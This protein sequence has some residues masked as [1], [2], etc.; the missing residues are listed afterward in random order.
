M[1][2]VKEITT[3]QELKRFVKFPFTLY[4]DSPYWVAPLTND[5][6]ETLDKTKNPVFKNATATYYLAYKEN[7]IVGR[8]AVIIN[9]L[10]IEEIGKKK[11]RFG[12]L[13]MIDDI[14]VTKALLEKVYEAGREN[15]L[16]YAEG[17]VGFS[18][19][20]KAGILTKGFEELNTMITWYHYPYYAEH[21]EKLGF[22]K[23]ATWVEY[24]LSIPAT[25]KE[26]VAKFSS[27]VKKRYELEVIEFKNKK[28]ILPY[29]NTMF[30]LLNKTYNSLQT[31]VP[32]QQYQIDYYKE[33]YFGFI[34]PDYITCIKD[35]NGALI[36]FS[37]VMPSF[38][39]ALKKANGSL[40]P[41]GWYHMWQAQRKNDRA[42]FY[43]I[44][45]DPEYQG[46]GVT[47]IIFE[48]MQYLFNSKGIDKVETNPELI[49]NTAVQLLWKDYEPVQHK[50]RS[51]F[52]KSI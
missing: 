20:E 19:M 13:D 15:K 17:P 37:I 2:K 49:E 51:T 47:A 24:R 26:K 38:S 7:K 14:E 35:K 39:K 46:K 11:V 50:E 33:K 52:K 23:Q 9:K 27:I 45:I 36:A 1:I 40:L 28:E 8:I 34:Q 43:L 29:V 31:F 22:E 10:E 18:N 25:I 41:F 5:E 21:F 16:E 30:E 3:Q 48:E 4:S 42:A 6:L 44:G 12:W 32:I